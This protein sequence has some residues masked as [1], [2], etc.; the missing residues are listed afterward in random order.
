[1]LYAIS[2]QGS[3]V[4][5]DS[6]SG[7][8]LW[9]KEASSINSLASNFENIVFINNDGVLVSLDKYTGRVKWKQSKF[10]KRLIGSPIIFN[11][12]IIVS[13]IENYL[14][15]INTD[16][17]SISGRIKIKDKIQSF[18]N[19]FDSLYILDKNFSLKKI[20]ISKTD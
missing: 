11:D 3:A 9:R 4:A 17:G 14:H 19:K 8:I 1:M 16:T 12:F 6:A 20:N 18:Y 15:I 5:I 13:D 2:Y 7:Q 10:F